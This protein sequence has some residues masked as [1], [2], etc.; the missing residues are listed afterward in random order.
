MPGVPACFDGWTP[1]EAESWFRDRSWVRA[2]TNRDLAAAAR[3]GKFPSD[4][5]CPL[6]VFPLRV[7]PLRDRVEDI[8]P[9][10]MYFVQQFAKKFGKP[11]TQVAE[12]ALRRLRADGWPRNVREQQNL[13]ERQHILAVLGETKGRI[14]GST[15]R[16]TSSA[17]RPARSGAAPRS[18]ASAARPPDARRVKLSGRC[19]FQGET[20]ASPRRI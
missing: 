15:A 7:P 9:L 19:G 4:L 13:V 5:F 16:R 14:E 11:V 20:H 3:E 10:V 12:D 1:R 2:G 6:S 17:S 8:L 18:S